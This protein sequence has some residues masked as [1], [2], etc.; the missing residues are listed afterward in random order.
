MRSTDAIPAAILAGAIA[1]A[2]PPA[3]AEEDP[4]HVRWS[5]DV[6]ATLVFAAGWMALVGLESEIVG[7]ECGWCAGPGPVDR[8]FRSAF[9][10]PDPAAAAMASDVLL[11]GVGA[12]FALSMDALAFRKGGGG[13]AVFG[14]D[15]AILV[16]AM[17]LTA[18][19]TQS[20]KISAHRERPYVLYGGDHP[21]Y[22]TGTDGV[23]SFFSLH[24]SFAASLAAATATL[25]FLRKRKAAPW[26]AAA[27]AALA[28]AIGA[29]RISADKHY[30]SDVATGLVVGAAIGVAVPILHALPLHAKGEPGPTVAVAPGPGSLSVAGTF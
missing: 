7:D 20:V 29:L 12:A 26:I 15:L 30:A 13:G 5:D 25:A 3:L 24:S 10:A 9:L 17:M 21:V 14:E 19:V 28:L 1:V 18:F 6:P 27:G 16:E 4:I 23:L 11:Y 22:G 8:A 2:P